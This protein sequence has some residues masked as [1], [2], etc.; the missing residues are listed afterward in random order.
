[1]ITERS[2]DPMA[3]NYDTHRILAQDR[4]VSNNTWETR[5]NNND[6]IIGPSGSG[7]TRSYVKP[8]LLQ[9]ALEGRRS[10]IVAD[11]KGSLVK[12]VGPVLAAHGYKVVNLDF[13]K[14]V[15][16]R[17]GYNPLAFIEY[18]PERK[19]YSEQEF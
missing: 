5:L 19:K 1:M 9:C 12:E 18:D 17:C 16:N 3:G 8:N 11:A 15:S 2:G 13:I 6:L 14:L 4:L 7:K 10:L